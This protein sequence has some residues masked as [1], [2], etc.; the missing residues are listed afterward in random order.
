VRACSQHDHEEVVDQALAE[1][2]SPDY[3]GKKPGKRCA[4]MSDF[5]PPI[6]RVEPLAQYTLGECEA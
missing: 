5:Y 3:D 6:H 1:F 4:N 2:N